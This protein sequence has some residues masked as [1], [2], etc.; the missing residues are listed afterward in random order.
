MLKQ[1]MQVYVTSLKNA[2]LLWEATKLKKVLPDNQS[3][4]LFLRTEAASLSLWDA[5]DYVLQFLFKKAHI[6]SSVNTV[7]RFL[8]KIEVKVME[9]IGLK[10]WEGI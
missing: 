6:A 7:V 4:T 10:N 1:L 3:V 2:Q 5:W 8:S 9:R